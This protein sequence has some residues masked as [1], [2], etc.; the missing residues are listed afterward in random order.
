MAAK[1][2][3]LRYAKD[4]LLAYDYWKREFPS[5][6]IEANP[7]AQAIHE[8]GNTAGNTKEF[9]SMV[10]AASDLLQKHSKDNTPDELMKQEKKSIAELRSRLAAAVSESQTVGAN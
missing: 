10:K 6:L 5:E 1:T 7:S 9:L 8:Y 4:V 3:Q 2:D